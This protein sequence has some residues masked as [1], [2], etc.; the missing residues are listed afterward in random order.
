MPLPK[1][2]GRRIGELLRNAAIATGSPR[3]I[4]LL[5]ECIADEL[6]EDNPHF[7]RAD[8]LRRAVVQHPKNRTPGICPI[9]GYAGDLCLGFEKVGE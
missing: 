4:Q 5:A 9:C 1:K 8:F 7:D 2:H 3:A 6:Q